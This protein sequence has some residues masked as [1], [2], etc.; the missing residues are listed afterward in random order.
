MVTCY[1]NVK[2]VIPLAYTSPFKIIDYI[3]NNEENHKIVNEIRD[4]DNYKQLKLTRPCVSWAGKFIKRANAGLS[5]FSGLMYFDIDENIKKSE[6]S[7]IPEVVATWS[8][9]SGKGVGFVISTNVT[10]E[11]DFTDTYN[12]FI[13]DYDLPIDKLK[14]IARLNIISSDKDL[15]YNENAVVYPSYSKPK[16][17]ITKKTFEYRQ[18]YY[19]NAAL[20]KTLSRGLDYYPGKRHNFVVSYFTLTNLF[21]VD[22]QTA[23][24]YV[25]NLYYLSDYS[26]KNSLDIYERYS[27]DFGKLRKSNSSY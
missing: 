23:F 4:S 14:D 2:S 24:D 10:N 21:G 18:D 5:E 13:D 16:E 25:N 8:S 12:K 27:N 20:N 22:Y 6:V 15:Y 19:C 26:I 17:I 11:S 1:K 3:K 7:K 9:L